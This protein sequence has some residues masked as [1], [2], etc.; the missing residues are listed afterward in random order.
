[1]LV[2]IGKKYLRPC[3]IQQIDIVDDK[4]FEVRF[5]NYR[6]DI[7]FETVESNDI[8]HAIK[9]IINECNQIEQIINN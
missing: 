7:E 5:A 1:M 3:N 2:K 6:G 9:V 4:T 8:E